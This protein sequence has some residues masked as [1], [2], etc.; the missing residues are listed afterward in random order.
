MWRPRATRKAWDSGTLDGLRQERY[1]IEL[2]VLRPQRKTAFRFRPEAP[3]SFSMPSLPHPLSPL[4][5]T[6]EPGR[7]RTAFSLAQAPRMSTALLES[8]SAA[9][10]QAQKASRCCRFWNSRTARAALEKTAAKCRRRPTPFDH[11]LRV[12]FSGGGL[13]KNPRNGRKTQH[14]RR[15]GG[16][17]IE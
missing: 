2:T 8:F 7:F 13:D 9:A 4:S 3:A 16:K 12:L 17:L 6:H 14:E 10:L 15:E 5:Q 1:Q 11:V